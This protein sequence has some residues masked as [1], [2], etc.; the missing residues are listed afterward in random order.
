MLSLDNLSHVEATIKRKSTSHTT[1]IQKTDFEYDLLSF[2]QM[3]V[4]PYN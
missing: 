4:A 1:V 2:C 3:Q